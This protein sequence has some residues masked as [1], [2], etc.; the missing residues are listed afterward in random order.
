V[1]AVL[2]VGVRDTVPPMRPPIPLAVAVVLACLACGGRVSEARDKACTAACH[3]AETRCEARCPHAR[4]VD[5][6]CTATCEKAETACTGKC[7]K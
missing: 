2:H 1:T 5:A 4:G 7:Q 3:E 6:A